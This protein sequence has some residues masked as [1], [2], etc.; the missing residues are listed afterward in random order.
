MLGL[1]AVVFFLVQAAQPAWAQAE[2]GGPASGPAATAEVAVVGSSDFD[3][4]YRVGPDD[5][6]EIRVHDEEDLSGEFVVLDT[7][8]IDMPPVG[9]VRVAGLTVYEVAAMLEDLL[10]DGYL[11]DP[12]V[13]A[14]VVSFGSQPVEVLGAVKEPGLYYLM[15]ETTLVEMLAKAGGVVSEKS[16]KEIHVTRHGQGGDEPIV[17]N[18]TRLM[19]YG[20]GN[21]VLQAGDVINV[22]EGLYVYVAGQVQN[23]GPVTYKDGLTVLQALTAAGGQTTTAKLRDAY[24]LRRGE[25]IVINL[26]RIMQGRDPDVVMEPEDQLYVQES[27]F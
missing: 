18:L 27:V 17:V 23:P 5:V 20:E 12:H 22:P 14:Q 11:K 6:L 8:D 3:R 16:I 2:E 1:L 7:G 13:S 21:M 10:K 24:I 15:G 9:N 4:H 25:R 26:K 19:A